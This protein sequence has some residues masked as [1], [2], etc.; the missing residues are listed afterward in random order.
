MELIHRFFLNF[1]FYKKWIAW[2]KTVVL[3][4]FYPLTVYHLLSFTY[5]EI[6]NRTLINRASS[7]AFHFMLAFFPATIFLF[8]LIPYIHVKNFQGNL[9]KLISTILPNNAYIAFQATLEDM[10][11]H[12]NGKLLSLGFFTALYFATSGITN[13]MQA[14]NKVSLVVEKRSWIKRRLIALGL[15]IVIS[16]LL[17][18]AITILTFG[19]KFIIMLK[20]HMI[21]KS[22]FWIF[23]LTLA[24][25]IIVI[26]IFFATI[27]LLYRYGPA[28]KEKWKFMSIGSIIA[29]TL[30]VL[31]SMAFAFY[32]N[33]FGS[34]NKIY[35]SI[36]TLVILMLWLYLNSF[37]LLIGFELNASIDYSKRIKKKTP[38]PKH[39]TF[40]K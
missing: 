24:R 27:S 1:S 19:V 38:R 11:R 16:V 37:I 22:H 39:N 18:V 14:F 29:T 28:N 36:G 23:L 21:S 17:L 15:T 12:Q 10:I 13:L 33:H 2:S 25:W 35:G 6:K 3:R 9:L 32:I 20:A 31:T 26:V 8:T 4:G 34:Y 30:A 5:H 40:K 7:L